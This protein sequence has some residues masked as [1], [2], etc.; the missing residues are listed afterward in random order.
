MAIDT[1]L[2]I[3]GIDGESTDEKH[4][5]EIEVLSFS[6]SVSQPTSA[7][8]STAGSLSAERAQFGDLVIVKAIDK[9]SPKLME[10]CCSGEH[11]K[12]ARLEMCR[13]GGDK[14]PYME[15]K[16]TDVLVTSVRPGGSG[17]GET[18]PLEEISFAYGKIEWK[19]TKLNVETGKAAGAVPGGWDLK[20]NKKV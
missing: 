7:S 11:L 15:Y 16:L 10:A 6:W 1:F 8:P 19:Y 12:S 13:A 3:E 5:K 20:L 9:A 4:K 2:K 17:H 18:V 14:E